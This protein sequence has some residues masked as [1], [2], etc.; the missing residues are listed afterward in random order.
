M[1]N[2]RVRRRPGSAIKRN[3]ACALVSCLAFCAQAHGQVGMISSAGPESQS[4]NTSPARNRQLVEDYG[5]LPLSFEANTGQ[6]DKSVKFLSRGNGYGLYLTDEEAVLALDRGDCGGLPASSVR[7]PGLSQ[8]GADCIHRTDVVRM[9]LEGSKRVGFPKG[10]EQLTGT[11]NYFIGSDP[12]KWHTSVPAYGRVRYRGVYPG[13]DLVYY[14]NQR[15]L[16]YDFVVAPGSDPKAIRLR[17]AG[18]KGLRLGADGDLEVTASGG[19]MAVHKPVVYQ[20]VNG[21]RKPVAGDFTLLAKHTVG[22]R[23]E[24]YDRGSPLIIDPVLVYSTYLG[25]TSSDTASAIAADAQGNVYIAGSAGSA[26]FPVTQGAL[27]ATNSAPPSG[28]V[29]KLD[30]TGTTLLY[31]THLGGIAGGVLAVDGAGNAYIAGTTYSNA[32]PT[33]PGAFQTTNPG[34]QTGFVSKLDPTGSVLVYSTYLG[35][36]PTYDGGTGA[37]A[38]TLDGAGNAYIAGVTYSADFPVTTGAFQTGYKGSVLSSNAFVTKLNA[39]GSAL[40]YSTYLGGSGAGVSS[41]GAPAFDGD[42]ATGLSVDTAGNAYITGY[43]YS[44]DFPVTAGAF[45]AKN[46]AFQTVGT[47]GVQPGSNA[48]VAKLN[49]TGTALVY[50]TYVGGSASNSAS[51]IAVD[52]S[53][54]AYIT[55]GVSSTDFPVTRTAL[56]ATNHSATGSNVFVAKLNPAG[57]ALLY[58][59]Y[60]GGSG[61]DSANG[62]VVDGSGNAYIAGGSSSTDFPVTQGALQTTNQSATGSN[63]FVTVLNPAGSALVYST[64]LGGS[65]DDGASGLALDG[66][67]NAYITGWASSTDFPVTSGAFQAT[68]HSTN[69]GS[70]AFVAKV[71]IAPAISGLSPNSATAGGAAF[72]LTVNGSGFATGSNVEWNGSV[73]V[74]SYISANQLSASIPASLI[75]AAGGASVTVLNSSTIASSAATFVVFSPG[76]NVQTISHIADGGGWR[77]SI[78]LVNTDTVP[79]LYAVN[80]WS[81]AGVSYAPPLALGAATGSIPVGGSTII[82]TADTASVLSEGWAQVMSNQSVGGTAIFRYDP[83]SQ[84][85]AVPLLSS[86]GVKLEIP[87]QVGS[88]LSL[89]VALANPSA[90]QSASL[91]EVIRDQNGNPLASRTLTLAAQN[92]TAFNPTFPSTVAGGGVVEYD[93]SV[94]VFGLGIR[95]APEGT[96]LAFTSL[97]AVLPLA[98]ST[99]TI[100]HIA[101]GGGWRSSIILVNTDTVP[102]SYT[103]SFLNDSGASYAPPLA[104]GTAT[105]SI[106]VG[107]ST[108]IETA[109]TAP[110]LITGW[111]QVTSSQSIGG[112]AIFR[113]DPWSQEAAVPL[114]TSGGATLEIPYQVGSG[115]A[116]GV[117]LANPSVTQT[118]N[119]TE[120]IRDQ[121]GN[122]LASRTLTLAPLNHTSFNPTF[123]STVAGGGVVE[124]DSNVNLFGL[125]IRS[126]PEGTGLAFTSVRAAYK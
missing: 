66:F 22:F 121:N 49:P 59:T 79:A 72:T 102:A 92:H 88:G 50:S 107:G 1:T 4:P 123:P 56:Q 45:Q 15:Q 78:I 87:Y 38:L 5:K 48:F 52:G 37:T 74:T 14:G 100:S 65:G 67:G 36:S 98:A 17:F 97:D 41:L 125:G 113:Y 27:Q 62:L 126:A 3:A 70:N 34:F 23:V 9:Q 82:E 33:T 108:I 25:G 124:Y 101:D 111:A 51:G 75:K 109:D 12:A 24:S 80:L 93:S 69:K 53:G 94:N 95:S 89:G 46:K 96:A 103:V 39:A 44:G 19:A 47:A 99:K 83:W 54:D 76:P 114:L 116:L 26:D 60:L 2:P 85:A 118:A 115:L 40:I 28:F 13:V 31:S 10:E 32:F 43:A 29:A 104:L 90:T 106:P 58:S 73:V 117:A 7:R 30:P 86:G 91:T 120:I 71:S 68:N 21:R 110:V 119:I 61:G 122:Q 11:A 105:G 57:S 16:E 77:S 84:E 64:Y 35:G 112:T 55:G 63:A 42:G 18:A 8:R 6:V 81:D 20:V